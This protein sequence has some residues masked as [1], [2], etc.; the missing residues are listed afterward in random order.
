VIAAVFISA[1]NSAYYNLLSCGQ[2][3]F[4]TKGKSLGH[5]HRT[6]CRGVRTNHSTVFSHMIPEVCD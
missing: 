5:G 1:V 6:V 4:H 2:T 3:L